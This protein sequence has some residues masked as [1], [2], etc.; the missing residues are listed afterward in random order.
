MGT[1]D[2]GELVRSPGDKLDLL[3]ASRAGGVVR[4]SRCSQSLGSTGTSLGSRLAPE[5]CVV[6]LGG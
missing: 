1:P 3:L 4:T 5:V 2:Y 6:G